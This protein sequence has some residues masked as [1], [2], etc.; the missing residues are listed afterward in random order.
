MTRSSAHDDSSKPVEELCRYP[1]QGWLANPRS[2]Q[3]NKMSGGPPPPPGRMA[4]Q[5]PHQRAGPPPPPG[6]AGPAVAAPPPTA[7][8][9]SRVGA[10][11]E[12]ATPGTAARRGGQPLGGRK[13]YVTGFMPLSL[14][15]MPVWQALLQFHHK[16]L[17]STRPR[18]Q[19]GKGRRD[20][21][22]RRTSRAR[23]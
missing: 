4:L 23:T 19:R 1:A 7:A 18:R 8:F 20:P 16:Q 17:Q 15:P 10:H 6:I 5:A 11:L 12:A 13:S 14:L 3:W 2:G 9:R 21:S 22:L